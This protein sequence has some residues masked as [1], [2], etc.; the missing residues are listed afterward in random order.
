MNLK[1][2]ICLK[3]GEKVTWNTGVGVDGTATYVILLS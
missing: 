2:F 3:I 1:H